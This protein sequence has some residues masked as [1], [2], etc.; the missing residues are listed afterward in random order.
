ME[1]K[2][3]KWIV[4]GNINKMKCGYELKNDYKKWSKYMGN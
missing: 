2:Y 3:S 4:C 1:R